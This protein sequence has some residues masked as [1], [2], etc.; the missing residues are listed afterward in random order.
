MSVAE[1]RDRALRVF[2]S[3]ANF[4]RWFPVAFLTNVVV[5]VTCAGYEL[6]TLASCV[7][8]SPRAELLHNA[9]KTLRVTGD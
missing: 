6:T 1:T 9:A 4:M 3:E 7:L 8:A 5:I 2:P